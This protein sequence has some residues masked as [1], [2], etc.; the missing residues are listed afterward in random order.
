MA[1]EAFT[2]S[3]DSYIG[4]RLDYLADTLAKPRNYLVKQ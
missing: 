4:H 1:T 2:V 3:T